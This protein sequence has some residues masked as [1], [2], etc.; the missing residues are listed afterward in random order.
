MGTLAR[1]GIIFL[2]HLIVMHVIT[3]FNPF[4]TGKIEKV[5]F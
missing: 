4:I 5:D 3:Y 2:S 1:N